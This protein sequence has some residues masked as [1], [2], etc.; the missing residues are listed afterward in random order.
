MTFTDTL[1]APVILISPDDQE[2]GVGALGNDAIED[3]ELE[4]EALSGATEYEWQLAEDADFS[5]VSF[6]GDTGSDSKEVPALE[7]TTV[8][9]WRVRA[10][11][12][13]LSPWSEEWSF[14]TATGDEVNGPEL[15]SPE[16]DATGVAIKPVFEWSSVAGAEGYELIVS[17]EA[18][19]EDPVV[20]KVSD[21]AL[22]STTWECNVKLDYDTTYYWKV[23]AIID[24]TYSAWST[25][26][27]FTTKE[28][29]ELPEGT[30]ASA[31]EPPPPEEEP[32]SPAEESSSPANTTTPER[33]K[34]L[35]GALL[36]AIILLSIIAFRL[37]RG[38]RRL[39]R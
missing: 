1:T 5:G 18:S 21:Y 30:V 39:Y 31:E 15:I 26:G 17:T 36:T 6:E 38:R 23:R 22:P 35:L 24:E 16:A 13:L 29:P 3:I 7:M 33:A 37:A 8:Y 4:W 25:V 20:L 9:Y 32:E 10:T 34:Y 27:T 14:T 12:P 2:E 11:E 19:L 28:E